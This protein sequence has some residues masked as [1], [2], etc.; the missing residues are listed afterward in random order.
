MSGQ[1]MAKLSGGSSISGS[2][3]ALVLATGCVSSSSVH[4]VTD[5]GENIVVSDALALD[6][7]SL[8]L[9]LPA[10]N[11]PS[12]V[13]VADLGRSSDGGGKDSACSCW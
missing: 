10:S 11:L 5:P 13:G 3:L 9:P 6:G 7:A 1:T 2:A 8:H 12:G 4:G